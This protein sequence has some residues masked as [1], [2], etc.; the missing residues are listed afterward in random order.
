M[1]NVI[2]IKK[3]CIFSLIGSVVTAVLSIGMLSFLM[4]S[5]IVLLSGILLILVMVVWG[6]IFLH[7]FQSR[8][9]NFTS[10]LCQI[11]DGM[12]NGNERPTIDYEAETQFARI[13]H[14]LDRLYNIMQEN[15]RKVADE[16]AELQSLVSDIS[17]QTK[18]PIANLKM[19]NE[20][21]LVRSVTPERQR[22]FLHA[23][24]S[25]LTKL[26]FLVQ[27]MVK[28]SRLET[29]VITLEKKY[30]SIADTLAIAINGILVL[31]E[32]KQ[33]S[34]SVDCPDDLLVSHDIRWTAEALFNL[35]DNA[36]KY[37]PIAGSICVKVSEWEMHIKIDVCDTGRGIPETEHAAI[38]QRFYR[39]DTVH[40][41]EG[42]G[43]GLY[44]TRE[45]VTMQGGYIKVTSET[46]AGS[47]FSV[48]LP[49]R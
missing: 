7:L 9:V 4:K 42:I 10:E 16:K 2:S 38:F 36:V 29:G 3:V 14:R 19:I 6:L 47:T 1:K 12:M 33:L 27:A 34:L 43:I 15:R 31:L 18:T 37:T 49:R 25:Q 8:L 11:L 17:H 5:R 32:Q 28:T 22:E 46:G 41:V 21:L 13:S 35:L 45:I 23:M 44:L 20:T 30:A 39:E 48:F 26:D 24:G 40:E